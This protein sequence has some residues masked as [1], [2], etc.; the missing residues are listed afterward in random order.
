MHCDVGGGYEECGL[1]DATLEWM[2]DNSQRPEH[3][4]LLVDNPKAGLKPLVNAKIHDSRDAL[5]KK[6]LY[7]E[8]VRAVR[9]GRQEPC[10]R[11][12]SLT[13]IRIPTFTIP[14]YR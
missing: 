7:R 13:P 1:S 8:E 2:I 5:W 12:S 9:R 6:L 11:A 3:P 4:L 10:R 14:G